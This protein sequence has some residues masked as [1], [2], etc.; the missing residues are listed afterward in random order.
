MT[1]WKRLTSNEL[2]KMPINC[3]FYSNNLW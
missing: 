1:I 3:S 2:T